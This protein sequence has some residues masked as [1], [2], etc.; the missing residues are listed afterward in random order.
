MK[1]FYIQI[2]LCECKKKNSKTHKIC[3]INNVVKK[4]KKG[5]FEKKNQTIPYNIF[6]AANGKL[7]I[8]L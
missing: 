2:H 3:K 5:V 6:V 8:K 4:S 1:K 7:N